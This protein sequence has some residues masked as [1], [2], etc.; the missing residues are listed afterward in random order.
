MQCRRIF[1]FQTFL[2]FYQFWMDP[3]LQDSIDPAMSLGLDLLQGIQVPWINDQ[4]F[5]T[6]YVCTHPQRLAAMRVVQII[7]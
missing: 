5:F 1:L 6:N 7:G 2:E 4:W 3:Q